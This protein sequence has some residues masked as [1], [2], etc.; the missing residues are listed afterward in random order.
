MRMLATHLESVQF[1]VE[2]EQGREAVAPVRV[3]DAELTAEATRIAS[4]ADDEQ[5]RE[6]IRS[7][8]RAA[9]RLAIESQKLAHAY[10]DLANTL[11]LVAKKLA[12][13]DKVEVRHVPQS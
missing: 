10:L 3:G 8:L 6:A 7:F 5:R 12:K 1:T 9:V 11:D 2:S 13:V 4:I